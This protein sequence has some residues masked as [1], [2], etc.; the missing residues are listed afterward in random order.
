MYKRFRF[1]RETN[2]FGT[3]VSMHLKDGSQ[4]E[5]IAENMEFDPI[6]RL[7]PRLRSGY[8]F[9]SP[10]INPHQWQSVFNT[11][12]QIVG[13]INIWA[14]Y[15]TKTEKTTAYAIVEDKSDAAMWAWAT[16]ETFQK[17]SEPQ[18][19]EARAEARKKP[20]KVKINKDGTVTIRVTTTT[21]ADDEETTDS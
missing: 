14:E 18:Q 5:Q 21:L 4:N 19:T 20:Q 17:W 2:V 16:V 7:S 1:E 6:K 13:K 11:L 8:F 10:G 9:R 3:R 15:D 12:E